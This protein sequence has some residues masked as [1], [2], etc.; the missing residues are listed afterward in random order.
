VENDSVRHSLLIGAPEKDRYL[1]FPDVTSD[2]VQA[3][4]ATGDAIG[5]IVSLDEIGDELQSRISGASRAEL[6]VERDSR[7]CK[8]RAWFPGTPDIPGLDC[9]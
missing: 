9:R 6:L 2:A 5:V 7:A 4:L 1:A 8:A 3:F